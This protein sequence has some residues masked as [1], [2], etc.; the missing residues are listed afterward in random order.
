VRRL[1]AVA[2]LVLAM[3]VVAAY[4][5]TRPERAAGD[6][7]V[8]VPTAGFFEDFSPSF[9]TSIADAY[10]LYMVQYYGEHIEADGRLD[11]MAELVDLVTQLSPRFIKAY[12]FG[13]F[14]LLDAG[15]G[16]AAYQILQRG[17]EANPD[18]WRLPALAGFLMYRYGQGETKNQ[19]AADWYARAAAVP[20]SPVY[21]ERLA[22]TLTAKG[23]EREKAQ[24]MW[25]QIYADG[26]KYSRAKA[27]TELDALLSTN[28]AVRAN[29]LNAVREAMSL[30]TFGMLLRDLGIEG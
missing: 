2:V 23:G 16:Q 9:R 24:L 26:D 18:E 29:E 21:L 25:A 30:K 12:Q 20:G 19:V 13:V 27:V 7:R 14:A 22:A 11:S 5:A 28:P 3:T 17:I 10:Y 1:V 4:Q 15:E 8:F 6:P